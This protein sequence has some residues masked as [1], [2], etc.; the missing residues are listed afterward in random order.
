M[1]VVKPEK[2]ALQRKDFNWEP[3]SQIE[4]GKYQVLKHHLLIKRETEY[5]FPSLFLLGLPWVSEGGSFL[6]LNSVTCPK[7]GT[8][9]E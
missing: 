1:H 7:T 5:H 3:D 9:E 8:R 2:Q 6:A 4:L